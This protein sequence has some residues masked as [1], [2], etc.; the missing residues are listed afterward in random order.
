MSLRKELLDRELQKYSASKRAT[1]SSSP[2]QNKPHGDRDSSSN[3][4]SAGSNDDEGG[5]AD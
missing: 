1:A 4:P 2:Q 5:H 3:H